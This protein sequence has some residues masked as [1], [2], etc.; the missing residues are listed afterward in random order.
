MEEFYFLSRTHLPR[1]PLG[2]LFGFPKKGL[3][4]SGVS[5]TVGCPISIGDGNEMQTSQTLGMI[6]SQKVNPYP[7]CPRD[8]TVLISHGPLTPPNSSSL[9]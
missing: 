6:I 9:L 5:H 3:A 1:G 8:I 7:F 4:W 2:M